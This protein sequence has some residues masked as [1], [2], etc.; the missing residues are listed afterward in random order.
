MLDNVRRALSSRCDWRLWAAA[1]AGLCGCYALSQSNYLL[2]HTLVELSTAVVS[3]AVFIFFWNSRQYL[4]NGF[5]LFIAVACLVAGTLDL[6]HALAF[7]GVSILP[8]MTGNESLQAK[9][10]GRWIA[11]LSFLIAPLFLRRR[12]NLP[13]TLTVYGAVLV[14]TLA[15]I[16]R[17]HVFPA[18]YVPGRGMTAF[19]H[20]SRGVNGATFLAAAALLARKRS[21]LDTGV[22]P[23]LFAALMA[24]AA[25]ELLSAELSDFHGPLNVLAHLSQLVSLY[26]VCQAMLVVSLRKLCNLAFIDLK[27]SQE[28]LHKEPVFIAAILETTGGLVAVMDAEGRLVRFSP[29]RENVTG[30]S[31]TELLGRHL[32]DCLTPPE[33][34]DAVEA[35]FHALCRGGGPSRMENPVVAK[36]GTAGSSSGRPPCCATP[37]GRSSSLPAPATTSPTNGWP[38]KRQARLLDD[39]KGSTGSRKN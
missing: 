29:G 13:L 19:E 20:V 22:F 17:W 39:S 7:Q 2:F 4:D 14:L 10:A 5:F 9:I 32:W 28:A 1:A 30:Y 33:E 15:A 36:D 18:C 38:N 23:L 6:T 37:K 27:S 16:F 3:C 11:S 24:N 25:L 21:C 12:I 35:Q 26:L 8:D 34:R 31:A